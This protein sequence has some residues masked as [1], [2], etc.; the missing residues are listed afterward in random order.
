MPKRL[1]FARLR[2]LESAF[3]EFEGG[4]GHF[5]VGSDSELL[6]G[7]IRC[8]HLIDYAKGLNDFGALLPE[9]KFPPRSEF[10]VLC[11]LR[12]YG[13]AAVEL[14]CRLREKYLLGKARG[15][16]SVADEGLDVW[17]AVDAWLQSWLYSPIWCRRPKTDSPLD[18]LRCIGST[19][20]TPHLRMSHA[21]LLQGFNLRLPTDYGNARRELLDIKGVFQRNVI[22]QTGAVAPKLE[23][24]LSRFPLMGWD[25]WQRAVYLLTNDVKPPS[26]FPI[27]GWRHDRVLTYKQEG[28]LFYTPE[29]EREYLGTSLSLHGLLFP[30]QIERVRK[31]SPARTAGLPVTSGR[32][33]RRMQ[34]ENTLR[35]V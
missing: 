12:V 21:F 19:N 3:A 11:A 5:H 26:H 2:D 27:F 4:N 35:G 8:S 15:M 25:I 34:R 14:W 29:M 6:W 24:L 33:L 16:R 1:P 10:V 7:N 23:A 17:Y 13:T 20:P 22:I 9:G 28:R 31:M 32:M 30:K 18:W